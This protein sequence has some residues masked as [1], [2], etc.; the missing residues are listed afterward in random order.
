MTHAQPGISYQYIASGF[1][2]VQMAVQC[3][4]FS[5]ASGSISGSCTG[6]QP[7]IPAK[8]YPYPTY[9]YTQAANVGIVTG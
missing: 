1:V 6:A 8:V 5:L 9:A 4:M 3:A 7:S 2:A